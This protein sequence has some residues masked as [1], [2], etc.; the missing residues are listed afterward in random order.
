MMGRESAVQLVL[1]INKDDCTVGNGNTSDEIGGH[2]CWFAASSTGI[3][4]AG[5]WSH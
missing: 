4:Q 3:A 1:S 2:Y 5:I